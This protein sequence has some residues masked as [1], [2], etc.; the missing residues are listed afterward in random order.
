LHDIGFKKLDVMFPLKI[1][2]S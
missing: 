1:L 2:L